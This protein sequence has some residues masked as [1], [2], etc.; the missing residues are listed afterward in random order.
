LS[1]QLLESN[2][3]RDENFHGVIFGVSPQTATNDQFWQSV[4]HTVGIG[5]R[6]ANVWLTALRRKGVVL[7]S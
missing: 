2:H 5:I 4:S 3:S 1:H 6:Q 7:M